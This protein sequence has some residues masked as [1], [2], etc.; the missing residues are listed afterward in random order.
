MVLG[1]MSGGNTSLSGQSIMIKQLR[2]R[3]EQEKG[4]LKTIKDSIAQAE[5]ELAQL[6]AAGQDIDEATIIFQKV[7][8]DTQNQLSWYVTDM[9]SAAIEAVFPEN[10]DYKLFLEFVQRRG[11]T[12]ADIFLADSEGNRIRPADA[13]GGGFIDVVAFILRP[14]LWSLD[15]TTRPVLI[16]DEPFRH[17]HSREYH[18]RV[19]ELLRTLSD[20]LGLQI[21]MVTGED[22]STEII[23]GADRI[24]RI[25]NGNLM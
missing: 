24:F 13:E 7:A 16:C 2:T 12:E 21:I 4:A 5:A 20:R 6:R 19:A 23:E 17:L 9:A 8:Q 1:W 3:L 22:E 18:G 15:R 25:A 14:T 10:Q 11:R